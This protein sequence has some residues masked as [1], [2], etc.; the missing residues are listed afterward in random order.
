ME[1][2]EHVWVARAEFDQLERSLGELTEKFGAME[3]RANDAE[4]RLKKFED[5]SKRGAKGA[6]DHGE[7]LAGTE[8]VLKSFGGTVGSTTDT[9][10]D[11]FE[12]LGKMGTTATVVGGTIGVATLAIGGM[13]AATY[14]LASLTAEATERLEKQGLAAEMPDGAVESV[15]DYRA[16]AKELHTA[17]DLLTA[18]FGGPF[19]DAAT[20]AMFAI[21]GITETVTWA[22]DGLT[23]LWTASTNV[24]WALSHLGPQGWIADAAVLAVGEAS[25]LAA[26][27]GRDMAK[28]HRDAADAAR[29][30]AASELDI[31]MALSEVEAEE[32]RR[33]KSA[34]EGERRLK[35][36]A[37]DRARDAKRAAEEAAAAAEKE[38]AAIR[39]FYLEQVDA[40]LEWQA[41]MQAGIDELA[42]GIDT[43]LTQAIDAG[44][45]E[46]QRSV[47]EGIE[48]IARGIDTVLVPAIAEAQ[49]ELA[50]LNAA[51]L[52]DLIVTLD[53]AIDDAKKLR[54]EAV[55]QYAG[56]AVDMASSFADMFEQLH[57]IETDRLADELAGLE[58]KKSKLKEIAE[59]EL[60]ED[61]RVSART[62]AKLA[63]VREETAARREALNAAFEAQQ[64]AAR[65]SAF[66]DAAAASLS[67]LGSMA[68]L[69]P[70][71]PA[72]VAAIVG[73]MLATQLAIIDN[74]E[75]PVRH[76]GG[77]LAPDE[78]GTGS[79]ILR[80]G[81]AQ[82]V[83]NQRAVQAG[84]VEQ[85]NQMNR[86]PGGMA[87]SRQLVLVDAG[88]V[89]G[90]AFLQEM[91]RP[92]SALAAAFG[93]TTGQVSRGQRF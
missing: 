27:H 34:E 15:R 86:N 46:W 4:Q 71:A 53:G 64:N 57:Q 69:G 55:K 12:G 77:G 31:Q 93:A 43:E 6:K 14:E 47:D 18:T 49:A 89:I 36:A 87:E 8:K 59:Q 9:V 22:A 70:F 45:R 3:K 35:K 72:A 80:D 82:V 65:A 26:D 88:R 68:Y 1:T 11:L 5:A 92:E 16:A 30:L 61:G 73:P 7:A 41:T 44:A 62:Q 21:A 25:E 48:E 50:Q 37:E 51:A 54:T 60:A 20:E 85:V 2:H 38:S 79:A 83:L 75:P 58:E 24:A 67:L 78:I 28:A 81:E 42:R 56:A 90:R 29:E 19:V 40:E 33:R 23:T 32:A 74:Q 10:F 66:L 84:G 17:V 52:D 76:D 13:A 91:A 63:A 39:K